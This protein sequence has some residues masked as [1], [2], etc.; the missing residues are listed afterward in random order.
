MLRLP[1]KAINWPYLIETDNIERTKQSII[2]YAIDIGFNKEVLLSGNSFDFKIIESEN[3][4]KVDDIRNELIDSIYLSPRFEQKKIYIVYDASQMNISAQ[5]ALLKTL[6]ELPDDAIIF[7]V[8][9]NI[10]KILDTIKSR[11]LVYYD[12]DEIVDVSMYESLE[13]FDEFVRAICDIK[14]GSS[15]SFIDLINNINDDKDKKND[16]LLYI[17]LLSV[18]LHDVLIYKKTLSRDLMYIA[19]KRDLLISLAGQHDVEF[20]WSFVSD[21]NKIKLLPNNNLDYKM[22]LINLYLK[23]K[24]KLETLRS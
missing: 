12:R 2:N 3:L 6:E 17:D 10:K 16:F 8:A 23:E 14:F 1:K 9:K 4:I 18:I 11:C 21:Y 7:L 22:I 15:N 19:A 24:Q 13:Y 20:W 5:N